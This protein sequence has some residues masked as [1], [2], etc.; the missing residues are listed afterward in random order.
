M[1]TFTV[2]RARAEFEHW[3]EAN[4]ELPVAAADHYGWDDMAKAFAAGMQAACDIT[5]ADHAAAAEWRK[6]AGLP[7]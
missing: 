2:S 3:A 5:A 7:S 6:R 4:A 1:T